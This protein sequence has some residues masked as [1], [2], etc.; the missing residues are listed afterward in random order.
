MVGIVGSDDSRIALVTAKALDGALPDLGKGSVRLIDHQV[1]VSAHQVCHRGA[2]AAIVHQCQ[3]GTGLLLEQC[4][5]HVTRA[6]DTRRTQRRPVRL[7]PG[8]QLGEIVGLDILS[9]DDDLRRAWEQGD[10]LEIRRKIIV[11]A[12]DRAVEHMGAPVPQAERIAVG[13]C[14]NDALDTDASPGARNIFDD[15]RLAQDAAHTIG[16]C[17]SE[18]VG[19]ASSGEWH[20]ER[21]RAGGIFRGMRPWKAEPQGKQDG[22]NL[23][24]G[25]PIW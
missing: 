24:H 20:D 1:D 16:D 17:P 11:E 3:L 21:D 25:S 8:D 19:W 4:S 5:A 18:R 9:R 23:L 14:A 7:C 2:T 12:I 6:T 15:D 13:R 10:R 22:E